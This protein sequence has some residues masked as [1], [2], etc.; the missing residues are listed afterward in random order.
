[1]EVAMRGGW[2]PLFAAL[3]FALL[4]SVAYSQTARGPPCADRDHIVSLLRKQH[5]EH[6][7][8]Y[9][10]SSTGI[11]FEIHAAADGGW[12]LIVTTADGRSCVIASGG[13]WQTVKPAD[14]T[15]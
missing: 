6:L 12:T 11:L 10:L 15:I 3:V 5:G 13:H 7:T 9:G 1:M 4:P 8:G 2:N 14:I